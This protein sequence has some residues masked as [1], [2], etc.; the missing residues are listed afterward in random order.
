I[1]YSSYFSY[2]DPNRTFVLPE[3]GTYRV[4]I[5]GDR[6]STGTYSFNILSSSKAIELDLSQEY[7][8]RI[9]PG[10]ETHLYS[11][12]GTK[13]QRF[14]LDSLTNTADG[15]WTIYA[16]DNNLPITADNT[17]NSNAA[18]NSF[19]NG[20]ALSNDF[21]VT[22]PGTGTYLLAIQGTSNNPINYQFQVLTPPT[23]VEELAADES[24]T[25]SIAG[26][27]AEKGERDIYTFE[28][29]QNQWLFLDA[30]SETPSTWMRLVG[31]SGQNILNSPIAAD[32]WQ[33]PVILSESGTY[34]L[35]VDGDKEAQDAY[36]FRLV[37]F[38]D[39]VTLPL[40]GD[41][42]TDRLFPASEVM[43]YQFQGG[44]NER[45]YIDATAT[46]ESN[47]A[48]LLL[49]KAGSTSSIASSNRL[50][51]I[52]TV[53]P[54]TGTYYLMVR[55]GNTP[56][57]S[58]PYSIQAFSYPETSGTPL[59]LNSSPVNGVISQPGEQ[60][61]YTFEVTDA[62][63]NQRWLFDLL[64]GNSIF[65]K[66]ES[67]S[68][69]LIFNNLY[70][71][72]HNSTF[73]LTEK[74][75]Y[76]LTL[77]GNSGTTGNYS[78]GFA[79]AA[80]VVP[81]TRTADTQLTLNAPT[82]VNLG[83]GWG[84]TTTYS[85]TGA[86][87][88]QI[89]YDSLSNNYS[90]AGVTLYSPSGKSEELG[91]SSPHS[92]G[93]VLT[94]SEEGNYYLEFT[95][96]NSSATSVNFRLTD[97]AS[98][99]TVGLDT[100]VSGS[101][102]NP[103]ETDLYRFT[104]NTPDSWLYFD[105]GIGSYNNWTLYAP[106][107][108]V[109][110]NTNLYYDFELEL[111]VPGEY[112][113]AMKGQG[114]TPSNY[115]FQI[116]SSVKEEPVEFS[117]GEVIEES[118]EVKGERDYYK[119]MGTAGERLVFDALEGSANIRAN[120]VSPTG[121]QILGSSGISSDWDLP[122]LEET[123]E[124]R[125]EIDAW[126]EATGDY[127]F[128]LVSG[129]PGVTGLVELDSPVSVSVSGERVELIN[130]TGSAGQEVY[131]KSDYTGS[132]SNWKVYN[133]YNNASL[134]SGFTGSDREFTLPADGTY[135]IALFGK[136][137]GTTHQIEI[138]TPEFSTS[139][140]SVGSLVTGTLP[141][142]GSRNTHTFTGEVGQQLLF[143]SLE[144]I[145]GLHVNIYSPSGKSVYTSTNFTVEQKP[146]TLT[147][148]GTY[149]VVI[150]GHQRTI[151]DSE[152]YQFR[153]LDVADT[154]HPNVQ[155]L[156]FN[157]TIVATLPSAKER[158]AYQFT[159]S[160]GQ[161]LYFDKLKQWNSSNG[162]GWVL[163]GTNNESLSNS[164]WWSPDIE[165]ELPN[166]GTY[167]LVVGGNTNDEDAESYQ[168]QL[169]TPPL[170][171]TSIEL[172]ETVSTLIGIPGERDTYTF[173]GTT[174]QRLFFDSLVGNSQI[175]TQLY[176]PSGTLI[177][178]NNSWGYSST[179]SSS[180]FSLTE[181]GE[182]RLVIDGNIDAIG[183]YGFRLVD[184]DAVS[185][186]TIGEAIENATLSGKKIDFYR[187]EAA[188]GQALY[189]DLESRWQNANWVLFGPD[190]KQVQ[191]LSSYNDFEVT[192]E[193]EGTYLLAVS[194]NSDA[195]IDYSFN[196][197]A[198]ATTETPLALGTTVSGSLTESGERHEYVF[199]GLIGQPLFFDSRQESTNITATLISPSGAQVNTG[200]P[201]NYIYG[202]S[203]P[204]TLTESGTYRLI[205]DGR[206]ETTGEYEFVLSDRAAVTQLSTDSTPVS[207]Q[208]L[209]NETQLYRLEGTKGQVL[210]FDL[211]AQRLEGASWTL[212]G[213]SNRAISTPSW[214]QGDF[215]ATLPSDGI[216]TL[217][218][219]ANSTPQ[220]RD[221]N[222]S[223]TSVPQNSVSNTGLNTPIS[224]N[225]AP[226]TTNSHRFTAAAGTQIVF[227]S[228]NNDYNN[229][230]IRMR[231][232]APD[233]S[234]LFENHDSRNDR[235]PFTL[236]VSGEYELQV[237]GFYPSSSG[238]YQ[239]QLL[240]LPSHVD[241]PS[242]NP[243]E[244]NAVTTGTL[245]PDLS[246]QIYAF[247]GQVGQQILL[248]NMA[249]SNIKTSL[250]DPNGSSVF[251]HSSASD[252][253]IHTLNQDG[254]Y[255]LAIER[256][257]PAARDYS[258]QLLN[259]GSG[260][261][262]KLNVPTKGQLASGQQA[263]LYKFTGEA[264]QKLYFDSLQGNWSNQWKLYGPGNNAQLNSNIYLS[265][266]FEVELPSDGEYTLYIEGG[267]S[268]T[269]VSYQFQVFQHE[270]A[271]Y[272][273][274]PG[275]GETASNANGSLGVFP[276][277]LSAKDPL[278]AE[279]I[280]NYNIRVWP[281]PGN[282]PPEIE[283]EPP[284]KVGLNQKAYRYQL[285]A[286]DPDGDSLRY[287][288]VEAPLGAIID[289]D[290]GELL[291]FPESAKPGDTANF[292][293]E[294][295]DARGGTALQNFTVDVYSALGKIQGAVFD[296]LNG[297]GYRDTT[298]VQGDSPNIVFAIDVSGS[299]GG[300]YVDW[301]E[302][303]LETVADKP[304]GILGMEIATAIALSEQLILQGRGNTT[305][306][307]LVSFN[308]D[309][310]IID[311]DPSL[312]G[313]QFF[314]TP[315]ADKDNNG[316]PDLR[317]ILNRF[318]AD[319]GTYFTPPL[320]K[321]EALLNSVPGDANLIFLS[322]GFGG[323]DTEVVDRL[324]A[325]GVNITAFGIGAGAG[326]G[327]LQRIDPDAI[328]VTNPREIID[329]FGGWD[330]RYTPEPLM[331]NV[332]VYLDLNENGQLDDG[333]PT[334]L[335]GKNKTES[336]LGSTP[337]HF[338]FDNLL[339]GTYTVRQL[340][341]NGYEETAPSTGAFV[342]TI[343]VTDGE[344]FSHL[345]GNHLIAP[346][347]NSIPSFI[348][349]APTDTI[350]VGEAFKYQ[351]N[352]LDADAEPL[353]YELTLFP[354]GMNINPES[355]TIVWRPTEEQ[356]GTF[357]AIVRVSDPSG[358]IDLQYFQVEVVP[359]NS[360][361]TFT[362]PSPTSIQPQ[363]GKLFE[364]RLN[365]LDA[366]GDA[367]IRYELVNP[368]TGVTLNP[369]TGILRWTPSQT[370]EFQFTVK[371]I[372]SLGGEASQ[373]ITAT[374]VEPRPNTPP[375]ITATPGGSVRIGS[376]YLYQLP[377][378]DS[379]GD[380]L[381]FNFLQSPTGMELDAEGRI[382]WTP[383]P[384][385]FGSHPISLEVSDGEDT[386]TLSW[387]LNVSNQTVNRAPSITSTPNLITN[388]E[389]VYQYQLEGFDP[390]GDLL[391]WTL[392]KAPSGMVID[393]NSGM[394]SWQPNAT[395][396]GEHTIA[397]RVTDATG[398]FVGQE[399]DLT[400]RGINTPPQIVSVPIT[401][402]A[403]GQEYRYQIASTDIENDGRRYSL[404]IA[405]DGMQIKPETGLITWT[406]T[407]Q[408]SGSVK[409]EVLVSD[410]QES[411]NRQTYTI[412][413]G[414]DAINHPP[415][416]TS[417]AK[418]FAATGVP[419]RYQIEA[420]DADNDALIYQPI[421]VPNGMT[422]D[423]NTGEL[424]WDSPTFGTH[425][426]VV[427]VNDGRLGA[428]QG[429]TLTVQND[430]PPVF[431]TNKPP[432]VAIP[433]RLFSYDIQATDPN[434]T[435]LTYR[436]DDAS[437]ALGITVDKL[438][439]LRWTPTVEN[440]GTHAITIEVMDELGTTATQTFNLEVSSDTISPLV[441][442][443]PSGVFIVDGDFEVPLGTPIT[444]FT[445]ATDN[446]GVEGVQLFVD[447][448][449]ITLTANGTASYTPSELGTL[450]A[451][452]VAY[453]AA[454]NLGESSIE[455]RVYDP[456]DLNPPIVELSP[457]LGDK[458]LTNFTDIIGTVTDDNLTKYV[459][460]IAPASG[461]EFVEIASGN[462]QISNAKLGDFDPTLL[463]NDTYILRLTATDE[464]GNSASTEQMVDV[465]GEL[466]LGNF[467][468]SFTD[469]EVPVAGI[470]INLTRTYDTLTTNQS[471]DFGYG[472]RLEFR[473]TDLRT[474]V[475]RDELY[476]QTGIPSVGF[477]EG[478][479]VYVTLPGGK[480]TGFTFKPV[481][482]PEIVKALRMGAP[483][484]QSMIFYNPAFETDD[485]SQVTL[486][487]QK[488]Q[489]LYNQ[490]TGQYY[491]PSGSPYNPANSFFGG[492][493]KLTTKEGI[494]YAID[495]TTGDLLTVTDT[496]GNTLTYSDEGI[497]SSTGKSVTFERNASGRIVAAVDPEGNKIQ[498]EYDEN[499]DLVGVT[500]REE[501]TT[502][503]EYHEEREHYLEEII[504]P[505]GR[506]GVRTEYDESGRLKRMLDVNGEAVELVY[507]PDNSTQT[508]LDVF[509]NP[510]TYVYD[511]RGNILTE[512]DAVGLVTRRTY[513]EDNNV[514][515]QTV[516]TNESG[517]EGW[518]TTYTYDAEGNKLSE[519]D[520]LGNV[521]WWSYNRLGQVL[522]ETDALGQTTTYSYDS[523]GNL[524]S[525]KDANGNVTE[526]NYDVRGNLLSVTNANNQT[527]EFRYDQF[528][529]VL[530][531]TDSLNNE[532]AYTYDINGNRVTETRTVTTPNGVEEL[533][534]RWEYDNEGRLVSTTDPENQTTEYEYD[535]N[536]NQIASTDAKGRQTES[537]YDEKGQLV[538]TIYP[539]STPENPTDNPRT[540]NVH[541]KGGRQRATIDE[542][543]RVTH[544]KY[545]AAGRL[546]ET[547]YLDKTDTL[548]QFIDAVAPGKTAATIDWGLVVYPDDL[549]TYLADNPRSVT[550]YNK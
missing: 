475:G 86:V 59:S 177:S 167:T 362:T 513:D 154:T 299:T 56:T 37:S 346:P 376:T 6:E 150:D 458:P 482:D 506:T 293:V 254:I 263:A 303:E 289:G 294:V 217:A 505:L 285:E 333:E 227:D 5:D 242:F 255:Y 490:E 85:F 260:T 175:T 10:Q 94:L 132:Y 202:D 266:D 465:A 184:V 349:T 408:Q 306:I 230:Q 14:Y 160:E 191:G 134:V 162:T 511:S 71:S 446:V 187:F 92:D 509:G 267:S 84:T 502:K 366:D 109:L 265:T 467:R 540:I 340:V 140:M 367:D 358:G 457:T 335:T 322:D 173:N 222:F 3:S 365:A 359:P 7:S 519:T 20:T 226:G 431:N 183:D 103:Q 521:T 523:R 194:G 341:P 171:T 2:N 378:T 428:A 532:T 382:V 310:S 336:L 401:A 210:N 46:S 410:T 290:R 152:G 99:T 363:R 247:T 205:V 497:F 314:T 96:W 50:G 324:N 403:V 443:L 104:V 510:T 188:E 455:I 309:A 520:P 342:D 320:E 286:F 23:N 149:R 58:V 30:L 136:G 111:P 54:G 332:T 297:N 190:S 61:V 57:G 494:E 196:A 176:S 450:T 456:N 76:R 27:M 516:V 8:G 477:E 80:P 493:Y 135:T 159:G 316:I 530:A 186:L 174:G 414:S 272:I 429:F 495:G 19:S 348:S 361:P 112:V 498:Y 507:D 21:E 351:A 503:F 445:N 102:T 25:F 488:T 15:K 357:E 396:L 203:Q 356:T 421:S 531:V 90:Y 73:P 172:G 79:P 163:Y 319:G 110:N 433:N 114:Y 533:V 118:I 35:I 11:F 28:A 296:D 77:D 474:S 492:S 426:I 193:I 113:L 250:Y 377:R 78:F 151:T 318:I 155:N 29:A 24:G 43:V 282:T 418:Y 51:D 241:A 238:N 236:P 39:G 420:T 354:E 385:Q 360:P 181:T 101:F 512:V 402:A 220:E 398:Y 547:I 302:A 137:S 430:L 470:P 368:P 87:G 146:F 542:A 372:D 252:S 284:T 501:N 292:T 18:I 468:L 329:I 34:Q 417:T 395:Q 125:L 313:V 355:G 13:G 371:A 276:V 127:S 42:I 550:E 491:H 304:M 287:R 156:P 441:Q 274:T 483:L 436:L 413:V 524:L 463:Q 425:Q 208:L 375:E 364:Y 74:G 392:D 239:F 216:Y 9:E 544:Y 262:L 120:L 300:N 514:L 381:T 404:G 237:D 283:S 536:G 451:K 62:N 200:L 60:D 115:N 40:N 334:Q 545:D 281:D 195:E 435:T 442:V 131:L 534:T 234:K 233:G 66:L 369:D 464:S 275:T 257:Q 178:M 517:A 243:V 307:G 343:T 253:S 393:P 508:V 489:L 280:Q 164:S 219:A 331:E 440:V 301:T 64:D 248:N 128:R 448:V 264:G 83:A 321:A 47:L 139:E 143:D 327:Q 211:D 444:F 469:L 453:D 500:D 273:L 129:V 209:P 400:V 496:N 224:G 461:G 91:T 41:S 199:A 432:T 476:E 32:Y 232:V 399:F 466:K 486:S 67:P 145:S 277:Q 106:G 213:P 390:D 268:A 107:G 525:T 17:S 522:T 153:I 82:T 406:P 147:E 311:L 48:D 278:G 452:A 479:R 325:N 44:E 312:P 419:Y 1:K 133:L 69:N 212:Y 543:G 258:F 317:E 55:G 339:P 270:A 4:E 88:Q 437:T 434:G 373:T 197:I 422:L 22:L 138:I 130:F 308:H 68:G 326:M 269:P 330:E 344:T 245:S 535:A 389:R 471:D 518:T 447:E 256:T 449:P 541:D 218:I 36:D 225:L 480:R 548:Q 179:D 49:Y 411:T 26:T 515:T 158:Q 117:I 462:S 261:D 72:S 122:I 89:F 352:A 31:P 481:M 148:S 180:P 439:R 383:T 423:V 123:G 527:T 185:T 298:L 204:F 244:F 279:D 201:S 65:A 126:G 305:Q 169:V 192:T 484:P 33:A 526:F 229:W 416:I 95:N 529:N 546:T 198:P 221:Y 165:L 100:N 166:T 537:R 124:Y 170:E 271:S 288:L 215:Q 412:E 315:L 388:L 549:P 427:G 259:L 374:V 214:L 251:S 116:V 52:E 487:A 12:K 459:L 246:K 70:S 405:P 161:R 350:E 353:T 141:E 337:Y 45:I 81:V 409:V 485:G 142:M 407:A 473:D 460:S 93:K 38:T 53:L 478:T 472:W 538:E 235:E 144:G 121:K 228:L 379:D 231:L 168:F 240:E 528:G 249:G 345:F 394:L 182:Y 328:Q 438:G 189:F 499:G 119:F 63:L 16:P 295:N 384:S 386:T 157:E 397:I 97:I 539:D 504:D 206:N 424:H 415:V 380:P 75:I 454:G 207:V 291:W 347:L 98:T 387:T 391:L 223:V 105:S 108:R 323:V 338:T 370:G